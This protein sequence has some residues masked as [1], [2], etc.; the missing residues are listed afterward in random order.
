V[1]GHSHGKGNTRFRDC[2]EE[3]SD[4]SLLRFF[5]QPRRTKLSSR[6]KVVFYRFYVQPRSLSNLPATQRLR[7]F[8]KCL[9]DVLFP[10]CQVGTWWRRESNRYR[11]PDL[12]RS[13]QGLDDFR[14]TRAKV[15][16]VHKASEK[17]SK[18]GPG[19]LLLFG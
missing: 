4:V 15:G 3:F 5:N 17:W 2:L 1:Q 14:V 10:R 16:I 8:T 11:Q 7:G 6:T 9:Q 13:C 18:S 19:L 12:C